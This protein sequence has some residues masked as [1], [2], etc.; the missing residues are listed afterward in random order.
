M[1]AAYAH[2]FKAKASKAFQSAI[3]YRAATSIH[4]SVTKH[5]TANSTQWLSHDIKLTQR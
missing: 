2:Y 1:D 3:M 5:F 4:F